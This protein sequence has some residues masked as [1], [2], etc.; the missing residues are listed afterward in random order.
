MQKLRCLLSFAFLIFCTCSSQSQSCNRNYQCRSGKC[1]STGRC[2]E[3]GLLCPCE[4]SADCG[5]EEECPSGYCLKKL[6][7]PTRSYPPWDP[8]TSSLRIHF[9]FAPH[10][11]SFD[12]K[13]L[14][15]EL[16][17]NGKCSKLGLFFRD[18]GATVT[19]I[20]FLVTAFVAI[21]VC[22]SRQRTRHRPVL[23]SSNERPTSTDG[24][25]RNGQDTCEPD[26]SIPGQAIEMTMID[27]HAIGDDSSELPI[28][29]P[30]PYNLLEIDRNSILEHSPPSYDEAVQNS[31]IPPA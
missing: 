14:G 23:A 29:D 10:R 11:C 24:C 21:G 3:S 28:L 19:T 18:V 5:F 30:P 8:P 4:G 22:Y 16:C 26:E 31:G 27:I 12:S 15:D 7:Q 13:C 6:T 2:A 1:C 25:G 9:T 17:Y 20:L